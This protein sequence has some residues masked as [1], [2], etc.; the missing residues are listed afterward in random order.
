M[1]EE[2][3]TRLALKGMNVPESLTPEEIR[4][5][6]L[7]AMCDLNDAGEGVKAEQPCEN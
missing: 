3:M 5:L 7:V 6:C 1:T 4:E 2:E